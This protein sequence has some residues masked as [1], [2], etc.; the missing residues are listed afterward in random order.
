MRFAVIFVVLAA[1][2]A[3]PFLVWGASFELAFSREETTN[4]LQDYGS[5][6][7]IAGIGL[8][9]SDICLP[10]PGTA[11]MAALGGGYGPLLGGVV[12]AAGSWLSGSLAYLACRQFGH[13]AA[14]FLAGARDLERGRQFFRTTGGGWTVALS[15]LLPLLPEVI[16]CLAGLARMP[17]RAFFTALACGSVPMAFTFAAVGATSRESPILAIVLS[18]VL[19]LVLWPLAARSLYR[20]SRDGGD[21]R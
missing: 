2:F 20:K 15:R 5:W 18:A 9:A 7:W 17:T 13:R 6:A 21:S 8:L 10:G 11:V 12:G 16:A 3:I 1:L 14:L 19:P 4:W